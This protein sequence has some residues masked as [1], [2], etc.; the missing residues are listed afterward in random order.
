MTQNEFDILSD[1]FLK[2]ECTD[3]EIV[4]LEKWVDDQIETNKYFFDHSNWDNRDWELKLWNRIR[5]STE[6]KKISFRSKFNWIATGIA[7]CLIMVIGWLYYN[8][9]N[10]N[11]NST[12]GQFVNRGIESKN[13]AVKQQKI[14]LPDNSIV[15]LEKNASIIT[16]ENYGKRNRTVYLTG[17]AF[18][19]VKRNTKKPFLVY[20]G[21]L[22]T[23]VLGTS[24]SIKPKPNSKMIEVSVKT[25]K[26]SVYANE[27]HK[28]DKFN[29]VILTPN[30]KVTFN[31][32]LKTISQSI[33]D[34]PLIVSSEIVK[35]D[36]Q[37]EETTLDRITKIFEQAYGVEIVVSNPVLNHCVFTGELNGLTMY[38][39]LEFVCGSI[40]AK[41]ELRGTTIFII[42][43]GCK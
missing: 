10:T 32:E 13:I 18:F 34:L 38:K 11:T 30:Q 6:I 21:G 8:K 19:E 14:I 29:G 39:Q 22:V 4:F 23:E 42:G 40:N 7:A 16:D 17:E 41:Y 31:T 26:V 37:F 33:V 12:N 36:F 24:F 2:N 35:S 25:G 3:D 43:D 1:K 5:Q 28:T 27:T 15:I 9:N 20:S